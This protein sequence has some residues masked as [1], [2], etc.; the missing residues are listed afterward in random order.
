MTIVTTI[1]TAIR[2]ERTGNE[3]RP[4]KIIVTW[5]MEDE[6]GRM[7]TGTPQECFAEFEKWFPNMGMRWI[8]AENRVTFWEVIPCS[9]YVESPECELFAEEV[10]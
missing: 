8:R 9:K 5:Q 1:Q 2:D 6:S 3:E 7:F 4:T 10:I